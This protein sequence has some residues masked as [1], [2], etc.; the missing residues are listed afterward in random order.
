MA[1]YDAQ[2]QSAEPLYSAVRLLEEGVTR[3][4]NFALA[5]AMLARAHDALYANNA[6]HT[7]SRRAAAE[8]AL[9]QALRLRPDLGEVHSRRVTFCWLPPGII[10][11]FVRN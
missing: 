8:N 5:W 9:Q 4:P 1:N 10:P 2:T 11:R 3:D 7:D 6:D